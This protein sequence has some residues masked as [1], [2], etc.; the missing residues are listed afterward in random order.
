MATTLHIK[1][2]GKHLFQVSQDNLTILTDHLI[3]SFFTPSDFQYEK[4]QIIYLVIK[5]VIKISSINVLVA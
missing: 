2:Y 4:H 1:A 5:K 3:S